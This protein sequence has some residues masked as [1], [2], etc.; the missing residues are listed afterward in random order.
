MQSLQRGFATVDQSSVKRFDFWHTMV[1]REQRNRY[2]GCYFCCIN[3]ELLNC[4]N[5][6]LL[7]YPDP[8]FA[9]IPISH[10][11]DGPVLVFTNLPSLPI[12]IVGQDDQSNTME[13]YID[14]NFHAEGSSPLP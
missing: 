7:T 3:L 2:D 9:G 1:W 4:I 13:E 11:N 8:P 12:D 10:C 14:P 6:K 5:K